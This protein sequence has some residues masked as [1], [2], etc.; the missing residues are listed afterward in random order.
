MQEKTI[1]GT[2]YWTQTEEPAAQY[3]WLDREETCDVA[4]IGGGV[5]GALCAQRFAEAGVDTVLVSSEPV[6]YGMSAAALGIADYSVA[7][8]ISMLERKIGTD[9]AVRVYRLLHES[10]DRLEKLCGSLTM[11]VETVRRDA[12]QYTSDPRMGATFRQEYLIERH[13]GFDVELIDSADAMFDYS[14]EL[15]TGLLCKNAVLEMNP[16]RLT[17]ALV[18]DAAGR[19]ARIYENTR[20][21]QVCEEKDGVCLRCSTHFN[22]TAKH[23]IYAYG[24]REAESMDISNTKTNFCLVTEPVQGFEGWKDRAVLFDITPQT[25][26]LRTTPDDRIMICGLAAR[27]MNLEGRFGG[28]L[29]V[30]RIVQKKYEELDQRLRGMLKGIRGIKPAFRYSTLMPET[31]DNMPVIG[32]S[33]EMPSVIRAL[34]PGENGI[35]FAVLASRLILENYQGV[36]NRDINL[37][38]KDRKENLIKA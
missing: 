23:A 34:C 17:Q 8:G 6:G 9:A 31:T 36:K 10:V 32:F 22:I 18:S 14:F 29:S 26:T 27:L 24:A 3:P 35:A 2:P 20:V 4:V 19:G 25:V 38:S 5:T 37:F 33:P 16:Y 13:N 28:I 15:H 11:P 12:L 7:G 30:S 21:N 1:D